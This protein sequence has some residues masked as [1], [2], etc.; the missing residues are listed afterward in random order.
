[1]GKGNLM[2]KEPF[3]VRF[4]CQQADA[5][6]EEMMLFGIQVEMAEG[7]TLLKRPSKSPWLRAQNGFESTHHKHTPGETLWS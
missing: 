1:M 3:G 6:R 7:W 5:G 4:R 2:S